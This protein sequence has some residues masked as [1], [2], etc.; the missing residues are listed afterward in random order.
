[1]TLEYDSSRF[2]NLQHQVFYYSYE[3]KVRIV[4][5]NDCCNF[6]NE[7][8]GRSNFMNEIVVNKEIHEEIHT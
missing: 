7:M 6:M 1:M 5:L 8:G 2:I 3:V 4:C